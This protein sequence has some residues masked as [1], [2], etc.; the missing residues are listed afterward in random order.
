MFFSESP[1]GIFDNSTFPIA[2]SLVYVSIIS[3]PFFQN[4]H[5]Q[6]A[7]LYGIYNTFRFSS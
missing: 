5:K 7:M 6:V 3:P 4:F 2:S 1:T